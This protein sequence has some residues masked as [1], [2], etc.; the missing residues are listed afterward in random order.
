MKY[1]LIVF[2]IDGTIT[3]HIS[4]WRY[5]HEELDL[6]DVLARKYQEQF[7][8]GKINYRR[9]CELDAAHWKG[10][11]VRRL[12]EVFEKVRYSRN[13]A[14]A[15]KKLK[16]DGYKLAAISTGL[17]FITE[18][19]KNEFKFDY[20]AGNRLNVR[21]GKLTGGVRINI[22]HGAKGRTV[23]SILKKFGLKPSQMI[24]VGDSEGDIPMLKMAGFSI[25]FNSSSEELSGL[26]DYDCLTDD[27]M[28][29]YRKIKEV[30]G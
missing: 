10:M 30:S 1:K 15:L 14:K 29:V 9:F 19:V 13:A 21:K 24:A 11:E 18:R 5:I 27:F 26:V 3:R 16:K 6:W 22:S 12:Y 4:S 17:Q 2:D 23:R 25:G 28:E 20:V 8:A 7:L